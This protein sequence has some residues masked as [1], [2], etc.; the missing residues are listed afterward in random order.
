MIDRVGES[1][2][3]EREMKKK[4]PNENELHAT[5]C[6]CFFHDQRESIAVLSWWLYT[7]F[8]EI[9][10]QKGVKLHHH[11]QFLFFALLFRVINFSV[12]TI[13][14]PLKH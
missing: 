10:S 2:Q 8:L 1:T 9:C 6:E 3:R 14:Q 4:N 5:I 13:K 7:I 12:R 11:G